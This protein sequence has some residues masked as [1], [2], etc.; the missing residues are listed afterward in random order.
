M[1]RTYFLL[2]STSSFSYLQRCFINGKSVRLKNFPVSKSIY[3]FKQKTSS[4]SLFYSCIDIVIQLHL[5]M[6]PGPHKYAFRY[7]SKIKI[8]VVQFVF[9]LS[10]SFSCVYFS[11]QI[12]TDSYFWNLFDKKIM[13]KNKECIFFSQ[14]ERNNIR[15]QLLFR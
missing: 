6:V 3:L 5:D 11:K 10:F 12:A 8:D 2:K 7:C 14:K 13:I 15:F 9:S 1:L 4:Y